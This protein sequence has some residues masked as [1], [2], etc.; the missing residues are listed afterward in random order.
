M[1]TA[2]FKDVI[3]KGIDAA[4]LEVGKTYSVFWSPTMESPQ[5]MIKKGNKIVDIDRLSTRDRNR[6]M[7]ETKQ[8]RLSG[9]YDATLLGLRSSEGNITSSYT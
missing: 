1:P 4:K 2:Y 5:K 8:P 9:Y 7:K 3:E 6:L